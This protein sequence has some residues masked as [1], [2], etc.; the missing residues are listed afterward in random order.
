[1]PLSRINSATG[2]LACPGRSIS[3]RSAS[4]SLMWRNTN[5]SRSDLAKNLRLE[6]NWHRV[7]VSGPQFFQTFSAVLVQR[8]VVGDS[9]A[10]QQSSNAV[11]VPNA[12]PQQR[13]ARARPGGGPPHSGLA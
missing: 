13:R 4:T 9:L 2:E 3:S 10:E 5:S 12:L 7:S 11:R 8:I 6:V 1:M